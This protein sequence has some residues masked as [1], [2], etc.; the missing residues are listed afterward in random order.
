MVSKKLQKEY[1]EISV[2]AQLRLVS[3]TDG[4]ACSPQTT[5]RTQEEGVP[6][7]TSICFSFL[8][9]VSVRYTLGLQVIL[10]R[11]YQQIYC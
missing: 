5:R 10:P 9:R 2:K 3:V 1:W 6:K 7:I 4:F 8:T 11:W